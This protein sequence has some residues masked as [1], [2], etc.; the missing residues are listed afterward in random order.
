M[1]FLGLKLD[2]KLKSDIPKQPKSIL[3]KRV[4]GAICCWMSYLG[5]LNFSGQDSSDKLNN[6][7]LKIWHIVYSCWTLDNLLHYSSKVTIFSIIIKFQ[8]K[9][10]EAITG[11]ILVSVACPAIF[12]NLRMKRNEWVQYS[13]T[14]MTRLV[15]EWGEGEEK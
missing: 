10:Y 3:Q 9:F 6:S 13:S 7:I 11:P 4:G 5:L 14:W 15:S 8:Q 12:H 2:L 1:I